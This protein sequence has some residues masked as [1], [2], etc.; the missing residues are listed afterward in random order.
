V[1][2]G[3][4]LPKCKQST[5]WCWEG[6][7]RRQP[8]GVREKQRQKRL[9]LVPPELRRK[10]CPERLWPP[11]RRWCSGCQS[12]VLLVDCTGSRCKT[13]A[14]VGSHSSRLIAEY[15]VTREFFEALL[16]LQGGVCAI[17]GANIRSKRPAMDHDHLTGRSRGLVC[18][19]NDWG[20]N[21]K[22]LAKMDHSGDPLAMAYRLV[23]YFTDPPAAKV[24]VK[25]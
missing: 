17:C 24:Q 12:F 8:I 20:C 21:M 6:W 5:R 11:G 7:L 2:E 15:G 16:E 4:E 10:V 1:D 19:D 9:A 25:A 3:C 18:A 13:C 14:S 23:A 22:I